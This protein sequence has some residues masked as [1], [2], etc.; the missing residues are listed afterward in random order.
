MERGRRSAPWR[1]GG[2]MRE[3]LN[4]LEEMKGKKEVRSSGVYIDGKLW[5]SKPIKV[6]K[7]KKA[8]GKYVDKVKWKQIKKDEK[9][10][11]GSSQRR[12]WTDDDWIKWIVNSIRV[13]NSE[14]SDDDMIKNP[15][16]AIASLRM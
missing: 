8:F 7:F 12:D 13:D 5:R 6:S 1:I 4:K 16:R 14:M 11:M 15:G 2:N 9:S 10:G 3:L